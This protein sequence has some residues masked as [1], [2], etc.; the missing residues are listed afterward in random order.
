ME[1][2]LSLKREDFAQNLIAV[3][4]DCGLP[5]CLAYEVLK[6]VTAEV[7]LLAQRQYEED[8]KL[9]EES[10]KTEVAENV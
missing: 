6:N 7:N 3:V 5:P 9:Y 10:L 8:K 1:K 2:P 4:N